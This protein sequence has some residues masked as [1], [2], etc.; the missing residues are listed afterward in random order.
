MKTC[1]IGV[2][3]FHL[4]GGSRP[5]PTKLSLALSAEW[6]HKGAMPGTARRMTLPLITNNQLNSWFNFFNS[7]LLIPGWVKFVEPNK[8]LLDID[9]GVPD[10]P[11][12]TQPLPGP[13]C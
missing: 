9:F 1:E 5:G 11:M 2:M 7:I 6:G 4:K 8:V 13:G 3:N 12:F 10:K